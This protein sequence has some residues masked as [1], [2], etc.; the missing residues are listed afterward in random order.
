MNTAN[1]GASWL[2]RLFLFPD[3]EFLDW[4]C[5]IDC[6][7]LLLFFT[8]IPKVFTHTIAVDTV[9]SGRMMRQLSQL[10]A[11]VCI[12]VDGDYKIE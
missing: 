7:E 8:C 3:V 11:E 10:T 4:E 1:G 2:C 9:S 12:S 6:I 5:N